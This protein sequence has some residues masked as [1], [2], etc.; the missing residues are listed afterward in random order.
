MGRK[1]IVTLSL[2]AAGIAVMLLFIP[3]L[4]QDPRIGRLMRQEEG[5]LPPDEPALSTVSTAWDGNIE[6][7]TTTMD[8]VVPFTSVYRVGD[9]N[10]LLGLRYRVDRAE[11]TKKSADFQKKDYYYDLRYRTDMVMTEDVP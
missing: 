6:R 7:D 11:L 2:A 8:M 10:T 9:E 1:K 4:L 5:V 3:T